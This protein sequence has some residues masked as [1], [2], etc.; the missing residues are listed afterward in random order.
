MGLIATVAVAGSIV[1]VVWL[2]VFMIREL[3]R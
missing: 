1:A 2:T 3:F